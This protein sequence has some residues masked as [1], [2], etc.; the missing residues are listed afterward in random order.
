MICRALRRAERCISSTFTSWKYAPSPPVTGSD[1]L[2]V[3]Q[4]KK[5]TL[6][7]GGSQLLNASYPSR[8]RKGLE[9]RLR[10]KDIDMLFGEYIDEAPAEGNLSVSTRSGKVLQGADL[11]VRQH[12][13]THTLW[14]LLLNTG[15]IL[16]C[17]LAGLHARGTPE[18][19][20]R[21]ILGIRHA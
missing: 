6:V 5:I 2:V 1:G 8:F 3:S 14:L 7:H 18:H 16:C 11:V 17:P 15:R 19:R 20:I 4:R 12:M 13:S 21:C 10:A 9:N